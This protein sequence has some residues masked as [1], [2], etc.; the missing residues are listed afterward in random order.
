MSAPTWP[1]PVRLL[2]PPDGWTRHHEELLEC[3]AI[4]ESSQADAALAAL[5]EINRLRDQVA[6]LE[7]D[8]IDQQPPTGSLAW[9]LGCLIGG[10]D[11]PPPLSP[12]LVVGAGGRYQLDRVC[13]VHGPGDDVEIELIIGDPAVGGVR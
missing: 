1:E 8:A 7:A 12:V 11:F 13:I 5:G 9:L 6:E 3:L 2:G 10:P 4:D